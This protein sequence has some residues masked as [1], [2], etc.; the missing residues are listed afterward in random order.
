[1]YLTHTNTPVLVKRGVDFYA[2][3]SKRKYRF[4]SETSKFAKWAAPQELHPT[5][6][7]EPATE[8]EFKMMYPHLPKFARIGCLDW[9]LVNNPDLIWR[10]TNDRPLNISKGVSI[11]PPYRLAPSASAIV[12]NPNPYLFGQFEFMVKHF[13]SFERN[14]DHQFESFDIYPK[15]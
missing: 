2:L 5:D 15:Q 7:Y 8:T 9:T 11:Y 1:M 3:T 4:I 6:R 14:D 12:N 13:P 10:Y